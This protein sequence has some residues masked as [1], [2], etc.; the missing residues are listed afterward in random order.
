MKPEYTSRL[1]QILDQYAKLKLVQ[2]DTDAAHAL[3]AKAAALQ[4]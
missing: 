3:Q 4:P 1:K 2:K